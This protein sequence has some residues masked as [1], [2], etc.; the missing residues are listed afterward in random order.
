LLGAC[1]D[2]PRY[3]ALCSAL[4]AVLGGVGHLRYCVAN[5][6]LDV[7]AES[8]EGVSRPRIVS[9]GWDTWKE[10]GMALRSDIP[11]R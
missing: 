7:L 6:C 9:I 11:P 8:L 10:T 1:G 2:E 4:A 3:I 5:A